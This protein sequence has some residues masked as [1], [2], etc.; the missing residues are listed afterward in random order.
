[1]ARALRVPLSNR[2]LHGDSGGAERRSWTGLDAPRRASLATNGIAFD[3][4][5]AAGTGVSDH[6]AGWLPGRDASARTER[7]GSPATARV[8][9]VGYRLH[10]PVLR[11]A[12]DDVSADGNA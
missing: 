6:G 4:C 1:L 10:H 7:T 5:A 12:V 8:C 3:L 11:R 9:T 2:A